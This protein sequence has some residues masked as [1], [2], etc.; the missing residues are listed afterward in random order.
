MI[1]LDLSMSAPSPEQRVPGVRVYGETLDEVPHELYIPPEALRV[2]LESFEG[3]L[4]LLLY[5]IRKAKFNILDIPMAN[6]TR[7]Y[8]DYVEA[9]RAR[10]LN[11]AAEYLVMAAIMIDI[12]CRMLLPRS[13]SELIEEEPTLD[14]RAELVR[15]LLHYEKIQKAAMRLNECPLAGRDFFWGQS[16]V[17]FEETLLQPQTSTS[18]L[19]LLWQE[20][21]T[22]L[23]ARAHFEVPT[24]TLSLREQMS[25]V[26]KKLQSSATRYVDFFSIF[27]QPSPLHWV[28]GFI[29]VLEL[30]KQGLIDL[31][32]AIDTPSAMIAP[33]YLRSAGA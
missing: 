11:L 23:R 14:P 13:S 1:N 7:Q 8:L 2:Y 33:L 10:N 21:L 25:Y 26:L 9:M 12:K 27:E 28:V 24:E 4:D 30:A 29:A 19:V 6:L 32:Q 16:E 15:R 5:L 18:E 20:I 31:E 22:R 17:R 3:P